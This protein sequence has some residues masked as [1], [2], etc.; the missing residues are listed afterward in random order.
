MVWNVEGSFAI[1]VCSSSRNVLQVDQ[2]S[3][4]FTELWPSERWKTYMLVKSCTPTTIIPTFQ[5]FT[6]QTARVQW[7]TARSLPIWSQYSS[8]YTKYHRME[9]ILQRLHIEWPKSWRWCNALSCMVF[10]FPICKRG[11]EF[12]GFRKS[13]DSWLDRKALR[14]L[15]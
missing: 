15:L 14:D 8:G 6:N 5:Y 9:D 11:S 2:M 12:F 13:I 4:S 7:Y 10:R 1:V 3:S